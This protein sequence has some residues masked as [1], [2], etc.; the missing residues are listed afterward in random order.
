MTTLHRLNNTM[1]LVALVLMAGAF[2]AP[3]SASA[4]DGVGHFSAQYKEMT[5][6]FEYY[7]ADPAQKIYSDFE[8]TAHR[9]CRYDSVRPISLTRA[10]KVCQAGLMDKVVDKLGRADVAAVHQ[11]RIPQ[12]V[13]ASR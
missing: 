12:V 2:L 9:A 5:V 10:E 11:N 6:R 7:R 13:V 8:R 4:D 3:Q 1:G